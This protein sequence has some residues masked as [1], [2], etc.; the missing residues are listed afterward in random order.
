MRLKKHLITEKTFR[1]NED[2]KFIYDKAFKK[3]V[4]DFAKGTVPAKIQQWIVD[5]KEIIITTFDSSEMQTKDAKAAHLV[6]PITIEAG[7]FNGSWYN[8]KKKVMRVGFPL[9]AANILLTKGAYDVPESQRT[10]LQNEMKETKV[11]ATIAHELSHWINDSTF[12]FQISKLVDIAAELKSAEV[13]KLHKRDVNMTHFEV[14]AII[15][16]I[17]AVKSKVGNKEWDT[18]TFKQVGELY[19]SLWSVI[20]KLEYYGDDVAGIYKKMVLKRMHREKLLGK[21][22]RKGI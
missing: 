19:T 3:F 2:V 20:K 18:L 14:D 9:D 4:K 22:M 12:G 1:V 15:H 8:P 17:K 21:N 7:I 13:L 16:G 11:K 5:Q 10:Y 6:N